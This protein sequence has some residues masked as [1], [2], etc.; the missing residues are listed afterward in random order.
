[1]NTLFNRL[2]MWLRA[3]FRRG[4]ADRELAREIESHIAMERDHLIAQ[5][6]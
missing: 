2:R 4:D 3:V 6:M 5:G 1:M